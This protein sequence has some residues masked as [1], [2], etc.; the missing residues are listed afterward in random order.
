MHIKKN[1]YNLKYVL[2]CSMIMFYFLNFYKIYSRAPIENKRKRVGIVGF[3]PDINL[4]NNLIK[5][6]MFTFLKNYGF[7]PILISFKKKCNIY[8]LRKYLE[9]KEITN[10]FT[11]LNQSDY[12][13]LMVNSDQ[14]WS[15][16]FPNIMEIGFLSFAKNWTISKF[17]YGASLGHDSWNLSSKIIN[18]ARKLVKQ[19]S[20]ISVRE[21][22]SVEI[23]KK[24]L[25]I[26]PTLVIDPTFLLNKNDYLKLIKNYTNDIDL[27]KNYLCVYIL[28]KKKILDDYIEN[29]SK[30]LNYHVLYI[31]PNVNN[32]IENFLF[33]LNKCKSMI[34]DSFHG[35]VFSLIFDKPFIT[36]VNERRGNARF[37]D[38]NQTFELYN[39]ILFYRKF[40]IKD[41]DILI[42]IPN[43]NKTRFEIMKNKSIKY[44]EKHLGIIK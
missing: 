37:F 44:L 31:T 18:Y 35:T 19:F 11:D 42:T 41:I 34:T 29:A 38:L 15:Y 32:Y 36:F 30:E 6:S 25:G 13:I 16:T 24:S 20:G 22:S 14:S 27:E 43:F 4:G 8:F 40:N 3:M 33:S 28:D 7:K 21:K 5:Y 10:Y 12:D 39:R 1:K 9:I 26:E 23:I 2:I 17:V